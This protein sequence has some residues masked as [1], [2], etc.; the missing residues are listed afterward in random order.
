LV[1]LIFDS[2]HKPATMFQCE[3]TFNVPL[4]DICL[5]TTGMYFRSVTHTQQERS[6]YSKVVDFYKLSKFVSLQF[7]LMISKQY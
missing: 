3:K 5:I 1:Q 6:Y 2:L 4:D 7:W